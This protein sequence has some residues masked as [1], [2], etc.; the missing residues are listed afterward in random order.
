MRKI[1]P[2]RKS[3][4]GCLNFSQGLQKRGGEGGEALG[5]PEQ[6]R[7]LQSPT[8]FWEREGGRRGKTIPAGKHCSRCLHW[9]FF[10]FLPWLSTKQ[11][12]L[13]LATANSQEGAGNAGGCVGRAHWE[14]G[15]P[16][17]RREGWNWGR[18]R[19]TQQGLSLCPPSSPSHTAHRK[20][21]LCSPKLGTT[22]G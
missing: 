11:L 7:P 16:R 9:V 8:L 20:T 12:L 1:S 15:P 10:F 13:L 5:F 19:G 6:D 14:W 2:V 21:H 22:P 18:A 17:G 3:S 4:V